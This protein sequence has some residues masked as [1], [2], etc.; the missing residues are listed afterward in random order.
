MP[1][2]SAFADEISQDP[3][4]HMDCMEA[5]GVKYIEL[6]GA[7]GQNVMKW[8]DEQ[9]MELK[10][11]YGDRGF[12]IAS[13]AS[14]IGKIKMDDDY[15]KHFDEFKRAVDLAEMFD[16]PYIRI[17][18]FYPAEGQDIADDRGKVLARLE[19]MVSY[20][21]DYDVTLALENESNLFGAY[22]ERCAYLAEALDTKQ[23]VMAFDPANFV[24]MGVKDIYRTCWL[25]LKKYVGYFHIKDWKYGDK[26]G[27]PA[28][29]GDGDIPKIL[30]DAASNRYD[31]F[32]AL[33]PHLAKGGQFS[34]ETGPE[35][36]KVATDALKKIC[37]NVG[38][39][40]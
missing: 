18:S 21:V 14:P 38:W 17:F 23:L 10:K 33:E 39:K 9:C 26:I 4:E 2:I 8:T 12:G 1:K 6:R 36:F 27:V 22:P 5:N 37:G 7:W 15:R 24:V 11:M 35:L 29:E 31:G 28:G 25:P 13:I 3:K 32:L 30:S 16:A 20:V 40:V 34:G 19:E